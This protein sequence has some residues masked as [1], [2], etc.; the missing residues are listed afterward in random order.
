[1]SA[2]GDSDKIKHTASR[3]LQAPRHGLL[4][5]AGTFSVGERYKCMNRAP[6]GGRS[7]GGIALA[8]EKIGFR[9]EP[10]SKTT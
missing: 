1:M 9:R 3:Q 6:K 5:M 8:P 10:L 4:P 7:T 2:W